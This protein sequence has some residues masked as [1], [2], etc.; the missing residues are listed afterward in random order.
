MLIERLQD[1][2]RLREQR[3]QHLDAIHNTVQQISQQL[4]VT[5]FNR[6]KN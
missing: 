4:Y 2:E 5:A 3:D 6:G 1:E